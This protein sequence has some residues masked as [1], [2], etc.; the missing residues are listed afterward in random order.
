M[1][2]QGRRGI[3]GGARGLERRCGVGGGVPAGAALGHE[4]AGRAR[5]QGPQAA[6]GRAAAGGGA[7]AGRPTAGAAAAHGRP[8]R[9]SMFP[10]AVAADSLGEMVGE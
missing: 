4:G 9:R 7:C 3:G 10:A 2:G 6:A 5:D 8:R 1:Q